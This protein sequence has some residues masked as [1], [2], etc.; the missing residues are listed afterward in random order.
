MATFPWPSTWTWSENVR[1]EIQLLP[2]NV[3]HGIHF[4]IQIADTFSV[5][6]SGFLPCNNRD[7]FR[8]SSTTSLAAGPKRVDDQATKMF[9][10]SCKA[11]KKKYY[12]N[13]SEKPKT[14]INQRPNANETSKGGNFVSVAVS[15]LL[16]LLP[17]IDVTL[18]VLWQQLLLFPYA[19]FHFDSSKATQQR[20]YWMFPEL[21]LAGWMHTEH[22][23]D[24]VIRKLGWIKRNG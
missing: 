10:A 17:V 21:F 15:V 20:G 14:K 16:L 24:K 5:F 4:Q 9:T 6:F 18:Q 22:E 8:I 7:N 23:I 12:T 13:K 19:N 11:A 3:G 1:R 2:A